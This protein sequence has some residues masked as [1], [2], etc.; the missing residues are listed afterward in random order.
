MFFAAVS[1]FGGSCCDR[2]D[3]LIQADD[4][5]RVGDILG[6]GI[7]Y[8][9]EDLLFAREGDFGVKEIP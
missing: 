9:F 2:T 4:G 7:F 1:S 3:H 6:E 8:N 5:G